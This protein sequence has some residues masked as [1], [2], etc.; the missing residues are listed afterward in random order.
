[1]KLTIQETIY[2]KLTRS[3]DDLRKVDKRKDEV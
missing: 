1:L 2:G 3:K